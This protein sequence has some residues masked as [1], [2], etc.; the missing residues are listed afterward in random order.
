[1]DCNTQHTADNMAIEITKGDK[2][3][4]FYADESDP[5]TMVTCPECGFAEA[6]DLSNQKGSKAKFEIKCEC[7]HTFDA[8]FEWRRFAR[9][10]VQFR[11][12]FKNSETDSKG[13]VMVE[14]L[15]LGGLGF[16]LLEDYKVDP[17]DRLEV[18]FTLDNKLS[19]EVS[20]EIVVTSVRRNK[21][22]GRFTG[23]TRNRDL[24]VY[25]RFL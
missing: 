21:V 19:T 17:G 11:G 8:S 5:V 1:M 22:G 3:Y 16:T 4:T 18:S 23:S 20:P 2:L 15:S 24:E 7:G 10:N 6:V 13:F 14:S 25:L 9:K 12:V